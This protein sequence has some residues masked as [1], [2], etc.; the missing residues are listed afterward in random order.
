ML[1]I[2][3]IGGCAPANREDFIKEV[4]KADPEFSSVLD[5]RKT[6]ANRIET[7]DRELALKRQTVDK[8]IKQLRRELSEAAN[9]MKQ[10]VKRTKDQMA[11]NRERI[12]LAVSI[13]SEQLKS[14]RLQRASLGRSVA[15]LRKA[16]K[17]GVA[18]ENAQ[19]ATRQQAQLDEMQLDSKRLDQEMVGLKEHIRLLKL[20]LLLIKL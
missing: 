20:K 4:L 16:I 11:P 13:A 17:S 5:K 9:S 8:K 12:D 1:A 19:E 2:L 15:R 6:L 14:M 3:W 10:K 18:A 7:Y